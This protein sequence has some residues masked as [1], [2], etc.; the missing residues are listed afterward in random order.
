MRNVSA[1]H[2]RS[3]RSSGMSR[4][5][6]LILRR[7]TAQ[8]TTVAVTTAHTTHHRASRR[9]P[10]VETDRRPVSVDCHSRAMAERPAITRAPIR[11]AV[12]RRRG[13]IEVKNSSTRL[14]IEPFVR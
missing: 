8:A 3:Q 10:M 4:T 5:D 2:A 1:G 13:A 14:P 7:R 12:V 9:F 6:E 11:T